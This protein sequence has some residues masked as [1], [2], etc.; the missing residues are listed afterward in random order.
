M[1]LGSDTMD[2]VLD[3]TRPHVLRSEAE[4]D[5]AIAEIERLLDLDPPAGSEEYERLE[6]LSVLAE[7]YEREHFPDLGDCSPQDVVDFMLEQKAMTR[8]DL[9]GLMGGKSRVSEFFSGKRKLSRGQIEALRA[10]LGIPA[11]LLL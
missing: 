3:F 8:A 7:A 11:D 2:A 10:V 5:A 6:F 9:H 1:P 4:Y